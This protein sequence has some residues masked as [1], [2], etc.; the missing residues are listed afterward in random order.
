MRGLSQVSPSW[1]HLGQR[2][3]SGSAR[4]L[5]LNKETPVSAGDGEQRWAG[6][7]PTPARRRLSASRLAFHRNSG[8][9]SR[10]PG[11]PR[12]TWR[13]AAALRFRGRRTSFPSFLPPFFFFC[14]KFYLQAAPVCVGCSF[15]PREGCRRPARSRAYG[16]TFREPFASSSLLRRMLLGLL[17]LLFFAGDEGS[18][19]KMELICF[20]FL[21]LVP[22]YS[23]GQGVYGKRRGGLR[24][25]RRGR[26]GLRRRR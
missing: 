9:A 15:P 22:L 14:L 19:L 17:W 1:Q 24:A 18:A 2:G 26:R 23:R 4:Q 3:T 16:A 20:L 7:T 12:A 25:G 21:S 5:P 13:G 11:D 6:P 8:A 10:F